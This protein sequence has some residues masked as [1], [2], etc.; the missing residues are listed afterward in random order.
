METGA[1]RPARSALAT[2]L[3]LL[4]RR[5]MTRVELAHRLRH[6]GFDEPQVAEALA[7]CDRYGYLDDRRV[8]QSRLQALE[9]RGWGPLRVQQELRR[10]GLDEADAAL[11]AH[12]APP[13]ETE[14]ARAE[15]ALRRQTAALRREPDPQRRRARAY[16]FLCRRGF[17]PEVALA[18]L[19]TLLPP[20]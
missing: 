17:S 1:S 8:A 4:A 20:D 14:Q 16:R 18:A 7:A 5:D 12:A 9:R 10:M 13:P 3:R 6:K 2:A 19:R 15:Q 11:L